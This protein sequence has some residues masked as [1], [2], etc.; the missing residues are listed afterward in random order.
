MAV[1]FLTEI[2][3]TSPYAVK[4]ADGSITN[5]EFQH[6]NG[7]TSAIQTQL[8]AKAPIASPTFTGEVSLPT[9]SVSATPLKFQA[10]TLNTTP[11]DGGVEMDANC[12]YGC[13]DAGN[14]G[15]IPVRH[16]IRA[17]ATRTLPSDS[18]ENAIFNSPANGRLT[19]G[20]GA[21]FFSGLIYVT[22]MSATSGNAS[23]DI[24]GAG[25]ATCAAWLWHAVG[26]DATAPTTAAAQT[27]SWSITQQ[28]AASVVPAGIGTAIAVNI[29]GTVEV[30]VAGTLIPAIDQVTGAAAVV[31]IGSYFRIERIG[32]T[33]VVSAGQ[34]D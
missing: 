30:T 32:S 28:S 20:V 19:L 14:R 23:I 26:I 11:V 27:G 6:L 34:W 17:D 7:V 1:L 3:A 10:G 13:T 16:F 4:L 24:L 15:Y 33:S 22:A 21:Y 2:K 29:T 12:I 9:G 25:T 31:A 5:T 8:D 18:N